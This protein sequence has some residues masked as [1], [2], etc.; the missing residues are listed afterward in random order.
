MIEHCPQGNKRAQPAA[1][2]LNQA[3][4]FRIDMPVEYFSVRGIMGQK[5]DDISALFL[6]PELYPHPVHSVEHIQ[7]H[8]SHVFL[9]GSHAYKI[10]KP[11]NLGFL[12]FSTLESRIFF[13]QE[14]LR[15]NRRL[16]PELYLQ[17]LG[18]VYKHGEYRLAPLADAGQDLVEPVL[19]MKQMDRS[20]QMDI[21][22][23]KGLV[24]PRHARELALL[25][26]RFYAKAQRGRDV[27]HYGR[28]A[29]VRF[30]VEENL[31]QTHNYQ[32]V[33]VATARW[34]A[35]RNYSLGFLEQN[36]ALL[37]S[38]VRNGFIV[39]GHGDL[40][41]GNINLPEDG[42]PLVFDCIEFN[43]RFRFQD[44]ACDLAFL[45]M[46]LDYHGR[47]ELSAALVDEYLQASK[48]QDLQKLINFYKCYRAVVRAKVYGFELEDPAV[49]PEQ[50]FT[51]V[52][53]AKDY[54][55]LA[56]HYA[57]LGG[58]PEPPFFM[59]CLM[60]LMGTGKSY[61]AKKLSQR[62]GWIHLNSDALRKQAAGLPKEARSYDGWGQGLYGP[63]AT[64]ATYDAMYEAAEGRLAIGD[65][66]VVDA[67]FRSN[68]ER[69]RFGESARSHGAQA[70]FVHVEASRN[71][72]S[73]R[74]RQRQAKGGSVS[75]GRLELYDRQAAAWERLSA[76]IQR[77]A[78]SVDGGAPEEEKVAVVMNCLK[79]LGHAH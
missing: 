37:A 70:L 43:Q 51:D 41:S 8:I 22:L 13:C 35:I 29:Q 11:L 25:L 32:G 14:E 77:H 63:E 62:L 36:Q 45:A 23:T 55:R 74:L 56:A 64:Q 34:R 66:V 78:I 42:P 27:A 5:T 31:N 17:V 52:D 50:K 71:I 24:A 72:V 54:F 28:P 3:F 60:G 2:Q 26:A 76:E 16:A 33:T 49:S 39:D 1:K 7:T 46:D 38:R 59:V 40:H 20:R 79:G 48:D 67:S 58:M 12:D 47:Q 69:R 15:L 73:K 18:L 30:N 4:G 53:K 19:Q 9:T 21:L 44:I 68:E 65:S 75:D 61:L 10:K 57:G 6:V